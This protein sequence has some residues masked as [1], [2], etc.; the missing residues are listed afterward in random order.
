MKTFLFLQAAKYKPGLTKKVPGLR[1]EIEPYD[2]QA[3]GASIMEAAIKSKSKGIV[4]ADPPGLGKTIQSLMPVASTR[5]MGDG[6]S[7]VV[8]PTSCVPQWDQETSK[9]FYEVRKLRRLHILL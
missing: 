9:F 7:L 3:A 2:H 6:P 1:P 5:E 4:N 8:C